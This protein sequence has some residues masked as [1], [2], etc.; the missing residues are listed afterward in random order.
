MKSFLVEYTHVEETTYRDWVVAE[1]RE[2]AEKKAEDG[3]VDFENIVDG[4]GIE[5]KDANVL[6]EREE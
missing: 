5:I 4:W 3:E 1:S 6:D 2:E